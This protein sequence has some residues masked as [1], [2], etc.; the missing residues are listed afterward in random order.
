MVGGAP[1]VATMTLCLQAYSP[2]GDDLHESGEIGG[3]FVACLQCG[4][5]LTQ[6]QG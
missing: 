4:C 5:E 1:E 2:C 6:L 3:V